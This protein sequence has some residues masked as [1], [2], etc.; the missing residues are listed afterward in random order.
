MISYDALPMTRT[1]GAEALE[2]W[3]VAEAGRTQKTL[4]TRLRVNQNTVWQ[5]I[6]GVHRPRISLRKRIAAVT[7]IPI[8]A[9]DTPDEKANRAKARAAFEQ[10]ATVGR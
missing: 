8:E 6:R 4:A 1:A 10:F 9:W 7:H 2:T 5:W 3:C